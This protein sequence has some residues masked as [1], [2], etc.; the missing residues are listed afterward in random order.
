MDYFKFVEEAN[1]DAIVFGDPAVLMTA[2]EVAPN[3]KLHWNTETI[4]DELVYM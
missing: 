3:M 4:G 1:A 2:R